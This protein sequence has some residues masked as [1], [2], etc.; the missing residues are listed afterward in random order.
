M[1]FYNLKTKKNHKQVFCDYEDQLETP[2]LKINKAKP[3]TRSVSLKKESSKLKKKPRN[4]KPSLTGK[5][6]LGLTH[7]HK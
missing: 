1:S 3:E 5:K 6:S 7:S 2:K 4:S